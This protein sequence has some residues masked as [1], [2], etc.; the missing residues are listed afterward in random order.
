DYR[1]WV[2]TPTGYTS[3]KN[4]EYPVVYTLVVRTEDIPST[5]DL[6]NQTVSENGTAEFIMVAIGFESDLEHDG[7]LKAQLTPT[8]K[9]EHDTFFLTQIK[10]NWPIDTP[11]DE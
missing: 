3:D 10:E 9:P 1:L 4:I 6:Y 11:I 2:F 7:L 5:A 8:N